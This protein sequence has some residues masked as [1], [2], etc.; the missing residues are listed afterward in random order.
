MKRKIKNFL[1]MNL[2]VKLNLFLMVLNGVFII[3]L[4]IN[5]LYINK[6]IIPEKTM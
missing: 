5:L 2:K 1:K 6:K 3:L 4:I